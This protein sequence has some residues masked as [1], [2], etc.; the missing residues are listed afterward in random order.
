MDR[1]LQTYLLSRRRVLQ[2]M[3][4]LPASAAFGRSALAAPST[5]LTFIGWQ[6]QPQ[7]AQAN[8][9]TFKKLYYENVA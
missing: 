3:A 5:P 1:M 7:I 8:L 6:Y 9:S 2:G 4:A